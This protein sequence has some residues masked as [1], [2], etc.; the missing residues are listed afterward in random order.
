MA[1]DKP[2]YKI[3]DRI[4]R[5]LDSPIIEDTTIVAILWDIA[6]E[7]YIY[8]I[9]CDSRLRSNIT[10]LHHTLSCIEVS[11]KLSKTQTLAFIAE[12]NVHS[13]N[14]PLQQCL[15]TIYKEIYK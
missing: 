1:M 10:Q 6:T 9:P 8:A 11:I 2:L 4:N 13:I 12:R 15:D 14:T 3:G 7:E 5:G